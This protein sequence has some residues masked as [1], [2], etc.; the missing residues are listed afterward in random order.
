MLRA[1]HGVYRAAS[2]AEVR[3]YIHVQLL[4]CSLAHYAAQL[5]IYRDSTYEGQA[6]CKGLA[7]LSLLALFKDRSVCGL[8]GAVEMCLQHICDHEMYMSDPGYRV[9]KPAMQ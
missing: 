6:C 4:L 1:Q 9:G 3:V 7:C 2:N 8:L 5:S